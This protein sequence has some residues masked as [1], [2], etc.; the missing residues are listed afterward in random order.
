MKKMRIGHDPRKLTE[1][2]G[3]VNK[4]HAPVLKKL[5]DELPYNSGAAPYVPQLE[6]TVVVE[7]RTQVLKESRDKWARKHSKL[8]TRKMEKL[9]D[10]LSETLNQQNERIHYLQHQNKGL[11]ETL[12]RHAT[13][14]TDVEMQKPKEIP[15]VIEKHTETVIKTEVPKLVWIG[16]AIS[17]LTNMFLLIAK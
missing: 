17:L 8:S 14:I 10:E 5:V 13:W 6:K 3:R 16:I 4:T 11:V 7:T 2:L 1:T 12:D 15:V 9:V